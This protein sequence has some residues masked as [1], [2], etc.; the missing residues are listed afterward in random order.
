[1]DD[2]VENDPLEPLN[3]MMFGFNGA[4][5]RV[6]FDPS[7]EAYHRWATPNVQRGVHNFF[8]NLR[9]PATVAS[10]L[11]EANMGGAGNAA[12]RFGI[13]TVLGVGGVLDPATGL[14]FPTDPRNLEQ[15]LC[16]F[17]LPTGPYLVLPIL[18]PAT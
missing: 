6:V 7:S 1:A 2:F 3:R 14:G 10:D 17:R 11:L 12:A 4:L 13:N 18:G 15:T 16:A 5:R 9:E 8:A